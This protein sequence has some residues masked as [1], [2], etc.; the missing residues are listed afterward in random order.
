M[1]FTFFF[2]DPDAI[3]LIPE[4]LLPIVAD[5][6][7][8]RIWDA[9]CANGPEVCSLLINLIWNSGE[10]IFS[11]I[12]VVAPDIDKSRIFGEIIISGAENIMDVQ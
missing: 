4:Y 12:T 3:K 11:K 1:V 7:D 8:M 9:G 5:K 10:K 2:R 6:E